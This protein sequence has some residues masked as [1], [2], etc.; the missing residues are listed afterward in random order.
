MAEK[1]SAVNVEVTTRDRRSLPAKPDER[2]DHVFGDDR[3]R[4]L[5]GSTNPRA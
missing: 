1:F 3:H 5:L 2:T 4:R